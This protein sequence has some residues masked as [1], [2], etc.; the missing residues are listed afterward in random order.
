MS[1]L[2]DLFRTERKE[3]VVFIDIGAS[4]VAGA[5][6]RYVG[7]EVPTIM[8]SRVIAIESQ[9]GED[10]TAAMLRTFEQ[11]I[12]A[13]RDEGR[14]ALLRA[15]DT[16]HIDAVL[17]SLDTPW[18]ETKIYAEETV[19]ERDFVFTKALTAEAIKNATL[20]VEGKVYTDASV[21]GTFLNGYTVRE[22]YGHKAHRSRVLVLT[23]LLD[24][25]VATALR[26]GIRSLTRS[27]RVALIAGAS[28]R[29]QT[30]RIAFAHELNALILD[31]TGPL[32]EVALMRDGFL[33]MVS[34]TAEDAARVEVTPELLTRRFAE[35]AE[36][37]PLPRTVFLLA[38][39]DQMEKM[40]E[41]FNAIA[42]TPIWLSSNPPR[43]LELTT[44]HMNGLVRYLGTTSPDLPLLLMALYYRYLEKPI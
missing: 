18:Q 2:S 13:L 26:R 27:H 41:V 34:E 36:Q 38:R 33:V 6:A 32:P 16:Q 12:T 21:V 24:E 1:F 40:K 20:P 8:Y 25:Q 4:R 7:T 14:P 10:H 35:V 28:L 22:P 5:L 17:V 29:Y 43:L 9:P 19:R 11:L 23:S 15:T 44:K 31:A 37:Y 3:S 42:Y 39:F 30:M